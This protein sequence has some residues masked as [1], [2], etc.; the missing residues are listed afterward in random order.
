MVL[1]FKSQMRINCCVF[2]LI[3]SAYIPSPNHEISVKK[4]DSFFGKGLLANWIGQNFYGW[5][6]LVVHKPKSHLNL[7]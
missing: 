7:N 6:N 1:A 4:S 5:I 2:H 3:Q